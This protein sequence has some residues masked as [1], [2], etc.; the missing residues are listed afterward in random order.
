M[1]S[2]KM[3]ISGIFAFFLLTIFLTYLPR[4]LLDMMLAG[5]V[6]T[7]VCFLLGTLIVFLGRKK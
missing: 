1:E 4:F 7:F 2:L 3:I 6:L 5:L